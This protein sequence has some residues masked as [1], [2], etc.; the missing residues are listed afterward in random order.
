MWKKPRTSNWTFVC[1]LKPLLCSWLFQAWQ[2]VNWLDMI[3]REC[4]MCGLEQ[5]FNKTFQTC[6]GRAH[7]KSIIQRNTIW[8][9]NILK[10]GKKN[11]DK[12]IETIMEETPFPIAK[13]AIVNKNF[14]FYTLK[15]FARKM[16]IHKWFQVNF[17]CYIQFLNKNK[18]I[19]KVFMF[20]LNFFYNS[21]VSCCSHAC[22]IKIQGV[23]KTRFATQKKLMATYQHFKNPNEL[24]VVVL[25]LLVGLIFIAFF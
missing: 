25:S 13:V 24:L 16:Y 14:K 23:G 18:D 10:G 4:S 17:F 22:G 20:S 2:R 19:N 12:N 6:N 15:R 21:I 3:K 11:L 7:E 5:A 9:R 8:K 1:L